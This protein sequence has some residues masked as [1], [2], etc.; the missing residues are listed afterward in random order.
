MG[1]HKYSRP[2]LAGYD[3]S[4][5][6]AEDQLANYTQFNAY[7]YV[8]FMPFSFPRSILNAATQFNEHVKFH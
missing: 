7:W 5:T 3:D 2:Q 1:K 6:T 4:S 8:L